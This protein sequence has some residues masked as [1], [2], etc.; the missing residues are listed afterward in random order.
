MPPRPFPFP[1][2]VGNDICNTQR[3]YNIVFKGTA[4]PSSERSS[5]NRFVPKLLTWPEQ[6]Y[7]YHRFRKRLEGYGSELDEDR[8][9][10]A[11]FLAGR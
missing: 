4:A 2:R 5:L 6:Q 11:A 7:F 9:K 8:K 10:I 3:I 1:F